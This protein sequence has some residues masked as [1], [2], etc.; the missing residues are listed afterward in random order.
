MDKH[1][2]LSFLLTVAIQTLLYTV[3]D[4]RQTLSSTWFIALVFGVS[5]Y[6]LEAGL[7]NLGRWRR[8]Q[9]KN[10][11]DLAQFRK[12]KAKERIKSSTPKQTRMKWVTLYASND[13][14]K[15]EL[16]HSLLTSHQ[17]EC[18][19]SNRHVASMFPS[20]EGLDMILQVKPEDYQEGQKILK[21]HNLEF[22]GK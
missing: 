21:Q 11:V 18:Q 17:I 8:P 9:H 19:I 4:S 3:T 14:A 6:L 1:L 20:I 15:I 22:K 12:R 7:P 16:L 10:V 5:W 2:G 13:R